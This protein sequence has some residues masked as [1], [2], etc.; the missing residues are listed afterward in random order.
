MALSGRFKP[1]PSQSAA[2]PSWESPSPRG[3]PPGGASGAPELEGQGAPRAACLLQPAPTWA[4][5]RPS[6]PRLVLS[7]QGTQAGGRPPP[8]R[9]VLSEQGTWAGGRPPRPRL[10]LS[11]QGTR[12]GGRPPPPS[13]VLS[14][15]GRPG[16]DSFAGSPMERHQR[17]CSLV[18]TVMDAPGGTARGGGG[19]ANASLLQPG[20]RSSCTN[21]RAH[22]YSGCCRRV[23]PSRP[24]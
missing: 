3:Q 18:L 11:E 10:V 21:L 1:S 24:G 13:L 16:T 17:C 12:A 7:K 2:P 19:A 20:T 14:E 23:Y 4:G 6:P 15:H 22:L 5:G 8:P 9:L